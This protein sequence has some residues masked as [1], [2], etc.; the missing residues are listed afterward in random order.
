ME[1]EIPP[2]NRVDQIREEL[3]SCHMPNFA[4]VAKRPK[5]AGKYDYSGYSPNVTSGDVVKRIL[6]GGDLQ[7]IY[8]GYLDMIAAYAL[9]LQAAD[10][11]LILRP[12]HGAF[13][14]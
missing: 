13:F 2:V 3:M 12:F 7:E 5:I 9:K 6:P 11:P 10:V 4:E 8:N 1:N 14:R